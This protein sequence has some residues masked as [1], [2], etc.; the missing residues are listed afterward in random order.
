[1]YR[2]SILDQYQYVSV[3]I[4][5]N[6]INAIHACLSHFSS[7]SSSHNWNLLDPGMTDAEETDRKGM[8]DADMTDATISASDEKGMPEEG[9]TEATASDLDEKEMTAFYGSSTDKYETGGDNSECEPKNSNDR[10]SQ[11][12]ILRGTTIVMECYNFLFG[13]TFHHNSR[14]PDG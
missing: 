10:L 11:Y 6:A 13:C 7:C 5:L 8:T 9:M 1:M 4:S 3:Y 12:L 2:D 14:P